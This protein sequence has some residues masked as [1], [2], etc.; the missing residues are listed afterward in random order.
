M[1]G[2]TK[3]GT[4]TIGIMCKDGIVLAADKRATAGFIV[5]KKVR[6]IATIADYAVVTFAGT[7][8]DIQLLVK[9]IQAELKLKDL[10]VN[11]NA[12]MKETAN[13]LAGL[14]YSN[15]RRMSFIPGITSFLLAGKDA[16][17]VHLFDI[18]VDGSALPIDDFVSDGSGSLF[19]LGTLEANFKKGL[20]VEDGVKLVVRAMNSA[21]QRDPGSGNGIDVVTITE[22]GIQTVIEKELVTVLEV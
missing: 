19:A 11:R 8:S 12:T 21:L 18:G 13:L 9:L 14:V 20:S 7:V 17:G 6:K 4:T 1:E 10:Q 2:Q 22:K 5:H 3:T 16:I 15:F